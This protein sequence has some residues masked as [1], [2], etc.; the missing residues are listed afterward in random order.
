M[1]PPRAGSAS[2][3]ASVASGISLSP[4]TA[5]DNKKNNPYVRHC[6]G[7][8]HG[9]SRGQLAI[10]RPL[11]KAQEAQDKNRLEEANAG[12]GAADSIAAVAIAKARHRPTASAKA[13]AYPCI[14]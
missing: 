7:F 12:V 5:G 11:S 13:F 10:F 9:K 3:A 2:D 1:A 14:L 6:I 4:S 8:K